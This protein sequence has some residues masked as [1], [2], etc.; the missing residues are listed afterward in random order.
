[1]DYAFS[2]AVERMRFSGATGYFGK[3]HGDVVDFSLGEPRDRPSEPVL[4]AYA[5]AVK[6]GNNRYAPVQGLPELREVTAG[7]LREKNRIE[8]N[9]EEVFITGGASEGIAF[10]IM[11]LVDRGDEVV[12]IEPSYPIISPMVSFCG[13]RP[14][15]MLLTM[16]N[17]FS[18][19]IE[20]LKKLV[21]RRTKMLVINTPHNPTGTVLEKRCLKAISEVFRGVI[22]TDE[23]YENF[24]YG[25]KHHSMASVSDLPENVITVNSFSKTYC[26]CGYRVGYLHASEDIIK[27][28]LKLKL[29]VS[30]STSSPAQRA[31]IAA[32]E[33]RRFPEIVKKRFESRRKLMLKGLNDLSIPHVGPK[34]AFYVFPDISEFGTDEDTFRFFLK[35]GVMTMP[36]TLFHDSCS[37]HVRFS[38]VADEN[39]IIEGISRLEGII[40]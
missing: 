22:L 27:R 20:E 3:N 14:V 15:S 30:T 40:A 29:C 17:G 32:L 38:F 39:E 16:E 18:L 1:V 26:M 5:K 8:A 11:S 23:V 34:G 13:G 33:D 35:A 10:S 9:P 37:R 12:I 4:E 36:G 7:K 28:M 6:E 2:D 21:N 19:D 31:A 24:T 25:T